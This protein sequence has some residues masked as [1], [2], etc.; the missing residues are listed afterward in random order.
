M[1]ASGIRRCTLST[2][3]P[4]SAGP[5]GLLVPSSIS[6]KSP[7]SGFCIKQQFHHGKIS[8][9]EASNGLMEP[10]SEF[11]N[12]YR[13]AW[14]EFVRRT[15]ALQDCLIASQPDRTSVELALLETEK[16]RLAYNAARDVLVAQMAG[17]QQAFRNQPLRPCRKKERFDRSRGCYGNSP[18]SLT[19]RHWPTG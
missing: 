15:N 2:R 16:A 8:T 1:K 3:A 12:Q 10:E 17:L 6:L 5:C 13:A 4:A 19:A 9:P 11:L 7:I 14:G 18:A